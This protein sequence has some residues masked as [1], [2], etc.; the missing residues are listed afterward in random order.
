MRAL[1]RGENNEALATRRYD[2]D[3]FLALVDEVTT[4]FHMPNSFERSKILAAC[5]HLANAL[6]RCRG[7]TLQQRWNDLE[8]RSWP[9][10]KAGVKRPGGTYWA[11]GARVLSAPIVV[12]SMDM[13]ANVRINR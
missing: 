8:K 1:K 3:K 5:R 11:W 7:S 9:K 2:R 10:W 12:P 6:D 4:H 13:V